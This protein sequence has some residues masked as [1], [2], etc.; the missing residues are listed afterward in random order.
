LVVKIP[1]TVLAVFITTFILSRNNLSISTAASLRPQRHWTEF[2]GKGTGHC[3][4]VSFEHFARG[5]QGKSSTAELHTFVH[6]VYVRF[7][8]WEAPH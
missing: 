4:A 5:A 1:N 8:L 6:I 3:I 2:P 7:T